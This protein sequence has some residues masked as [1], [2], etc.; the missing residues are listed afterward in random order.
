V[1]NNVVAALALDLVGNCLVFITYIHSEP[2]M[3]RRNWPGWFPVPGFEETFHDNACILDAGN[4]YITLP[5]GRGWKG[6]AA[7]G[8][9]WDKKESIRIHVRNNSVYAPQGQAM[10]SGCD[11][12]IPRPKPAGSTDPPEHDSGCRLFK[13][14]DC[15]GGYDLSNEPMGKVTSTAQDCMAECAKN[16]AC[17]IGVWGKTAQGTHKCYLKS[18]GPSLGTIGAYIGN[19]AFNCTPTCR[20]PK[21]RPAP[22]PHH[23]VGSAITF[24]Q[25][26]KIGVDPNSTIA[27]VPPTAEIIKMGLAVLN[28]K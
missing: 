2:L 14:T 21:P 25:W 17:A 20:P 22:P 5:S 9:A 18:Q 8:C 15:S 23:H 13:N 28:E 6:N 3:V 26:V 10:V 1:S 4:N 11:G 12:Q 7:T 16:C 27:E 19:V 24:A